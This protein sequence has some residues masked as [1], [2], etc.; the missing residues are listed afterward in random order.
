MEEIDIEVSSHYVKLRKVLFIRSSIFESRPPLS[1]ADISEY[2]L[3]IEQNPHKHTYTH[4]THTHTYIHILTHTRTHTHAHNTHKH[5]HTH[6][7]IY[8]TRY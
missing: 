1:F 3:F 4:T 8:T 2:G 6:I 7:D 5:I